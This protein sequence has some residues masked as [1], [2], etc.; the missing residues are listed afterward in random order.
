MVSGTAHHVTM[1]DRGRLVIPAELRHRAG[2]EQGV[3]LVLV[4]TPGGL[5]VL[6]RDR[7]KDLVRAQLAGDSLVDELVA[8]RRAAAVAERS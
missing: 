2:L 7:L 8:E 4:E 3:H 5:V 6:S 1:G